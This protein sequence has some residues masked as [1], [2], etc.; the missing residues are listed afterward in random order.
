MSLSDHR[1]GPAVAVADL[2]AAREFYEKKLGLR[3]GE[4]WEEEMA[5]YECGGDSTLMV[6]VS[7]DHAGKATHTL[8]GWEVPDLEAEM[9]ELESRGVEFARYDGTDGPATDERGI[10]TAEGMRVAWFMDPEGN[11]FAI[12]EI[13][14]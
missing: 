1:I 6:Y 10:F 5:L 13:S 4:A 9:S 12:N 2:T 3:V 7:P 8:A 14:S 11:T